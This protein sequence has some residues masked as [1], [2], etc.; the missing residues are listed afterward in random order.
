LENSF[1]DLDKMLTSA[2][3]TLDVAAAAIRDLDLAPETNVKRIGEALVSIFQIQ[4]E[5]Y[6][7]RPDLRPDFLDT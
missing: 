1:E 5:I 6:A 4:H 3:S 7:M 2:A